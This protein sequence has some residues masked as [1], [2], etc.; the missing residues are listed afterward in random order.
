MAEVLLYT[1]LAVPLKRSVSVA[2]SR[3][4]TQANEHLLD[5]AE[6][7]RKLTLVSAPAGYGKTVMVSEWLQGAGF[8]VAW[9]S[10]DESDNDPNRFMAYFIAAIQSVHAEFG[11]SIQAMIQTPQPPPMEVL[12]T[13]FVNE[14]VFLPSLLSLVLDDYHVITNITIHRQISFLLE[15]LPGR[16]HLVIITRED[17]LIPVSRLRVSNQVLEIRQDD[18]RFT[19]D[20]IADFMHQSMQLDLSAGDLIALERRTEGWIAGLQ[21]VA[22]S[23]HGQRDKTSFIQEFTDSNRYILDYLIE[24]VFNRQSDEVRG[25][26][27][28]TA[29][30]DR[31]CGSLCD[32]VCERTGS[33]ELLEHLEQ[34]NMFIVPLDPSRTWYRYHHLF[35]ELLRHQQDMAG[36]AVDCGKL[37]L[38]ACQWFETEG[39][40]AEAIQH[41]LE[42]KDWGKAARLIGQ[43]SDRMF[44]QGEIVTVNGWLEKLP[45]QI[46]L[47]QYNLCM[48]YAWVLLLAGKYELAKPVLEQAE[49]LAPPGT[50]LLGQVA[51]AQAYLARSVGDNL[52]VIEKSRLALE[53]LPEASLADRGNLL[54]NLG[55]VY[56]HEGHLDEAEAALIDAQEKAM[57]SANLYS[58]LTSEL[59][60]A[61]TLASRGKIREAA[62]K[63]P[64][65]IHR[66]PQIPVISLAYL[67]LGSLCY[68]WNQLDQAEHWLQQGL[69][70]SQRLGNVEFQIAG[71]LLQI[72]LLLAH[73]DWEAALRVSDQAY[74]LAGEFSAKF[75]ARCAGCRA[76]VAI[77]NGDLKSATYWLEQTSEDVDPHTFYRFLGLVRP[78][79]LLALGETQQ[80]AEQ[81]EKCY[82]TAFNSGWGYAV[83]AV[84]ILQAQAAQSH[85]T[86]L[87]FLSQALEL[88]QPQGYIRTFVDAGMELVPLLQDA[89][90]RGV[91][92]EYAG[93]LLACYG[94]KIAAPARINSLLVEPLSEREL[95]VLRLV[96]A[97][98][99]NREIASRLY[100]SPGTAKTH[101]HNLCGKLG[102]RNRTEAAMK[103][104]ELGI[105]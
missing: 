6:F 44:K 15:H 30:L 4:L 101:I 58:Q 48:I 56:W 87:E 41:A 40:L 70:L 28:K 90:Q 14:L 74:K 99:S 57:R 104:R 60:L 89:A 53:L 9:L 80:A 55:M 79:L 34:A 38:L 8:P 61:R 19:L 12:L 78:A 103:G 45:R 46:I 81:L 91:T 22:L 51:T 76:Q 82:A 93:R 1:K 36:L 94:T 33:R 98:F 42:A 24:E 7:L 16:V 102:V 64:S 27:L 17:P 25:F 62:E 31:L 10:L 59:F 32:A 105:V 50:V 88:A 37:H 5:G 2:R 39:Y 72:S 71:L 83:V 97:G 75:L 92:P 54:M 84:R 65:I 18:L 47:S 3:L 67:D 49:K 73:Q 66:G 26:L 29:I 77:A 52:G 100:I 35:L 23:L 69:T 11:K 20:E 63:Y 85:A 43:S 96:M 21:L 13:I 95:E 68:E 86:A